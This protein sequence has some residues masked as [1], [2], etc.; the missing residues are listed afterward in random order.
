MHLP[1]LLLFS[2]AV[3]P[4]LSENIY[5]PALPALAVYFKAPVTV[6]EATLSIYFAGFALGVFIWG[7]VADR[8][9][10]RPSMIAGWTVYILATWICS[11]STD[12]SVFFVARFVQAF[13]ASVGSVI[14][15]TMARD[16]HHGKE[17][18]VVFTKIG[19]YLALAPALGPLVG[20]TLSTY[21]GWQSNFYFLLVLSLSLLIYML[22]KLPETKPLNMPL[23]RPFWLMNKMIRDPLIWV[24][25]LV[26]ATS[27]GLAF[28]FY[29]EGPFIWENYFGYGMQSYGYL[30]V[31]FAGSAIFGGMIGH[32]LL[33][34]FNDDAMNLISAALLLVA[35]LSAYI[36]ML[37]CQN[38]MVQTSILICLVMMLFVSFNIGVPS[39]LATALQKYQNHVG[40][41][42]SIFG[43]MYYIIVALFTYGIS[44]FHNGLPTVYPLYFLS[45]SAFLLLVL[46]CKYFV[47][48]SNS[49]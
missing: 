2:M 23:P 29:A 15:Q 36:L 14:S 34:R 25:A 41:A 45:I 31:L 4:L 27:N 16:V 46:F 5:A 30:G 6:V 26:V 47:M 28:S 1:F 21:F 38:T 17:R 11:I 12:I 10:R 32:R 24:S 3:L 20:G 35:G 49:L 9:G 22:W 39:T 48:R 13:G 44:W 19:V 43:C 42:G 37:Y 18:S 8:I 7:Y 33:K 40:T